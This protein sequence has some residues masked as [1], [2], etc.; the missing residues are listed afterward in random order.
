LR[1]RIAPVLVAALAVLAVGAGTAGADTRTITAG[2]NVDPQNPP[3]GYPA[4]ADV[5]AYFVPNVTVHEGD[6]VE[7]QLLGFHNVVIG[8]AAPLDV[9]LA[10]KVSGAKDPAGKDF[11]FNGQPEIGVN[12]LAAFP[13]GDG[14]YDGTGLESSGLP[15][16]D[17]PPPPYKVTFT[18]AGTYSYLCSVHT[19]MTGK[20]KV[21]PA[22]EKVPSQ[23]EVDAAA[24]KQLADAIK[25][26]NKKLKTKVTGMKVYAGHDDKKSGVAFFDYFPKTKTIKVGQ[27]LRLAMSPGSPEVHTFTFGHENY[28]KERANAFFTPIMGPNGPEGFK[29][30]SIDV[31]P[32]DPKFNKAISPTSHGNGFVNSGNLDTNPKTPPKSHVD[33]KFGKAGTYEFICLV[34]P[35]MQG[36]IVVKAKKK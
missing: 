6:A 23:A 32:S 10:S 9:P 20:V 15:L 35:D 27:R 5:N 16:G 29:F 22:A 30:D 18:K 34:H 26:G 31:Y 11:W 17:G 21:V 1:K 12:P 2:P 8:G 36:T 3:K 13:A 7:W 28:L 14:T 24:K 33:V 25:R 4:G 19:G